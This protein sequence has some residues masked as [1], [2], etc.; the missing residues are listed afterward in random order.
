MSAGNARPWC[1][2]ALRDGVQRVLEAD[3][4]DL[5][6]V[7]T[8]EAAGAVALGIDPVRAFDLLGDAAAVRDLPRSEAR[9]LLARALSPARRGGRT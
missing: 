6:E 4:P 1:L 7:L 2:P 5:E 8:R 3:C 9:A